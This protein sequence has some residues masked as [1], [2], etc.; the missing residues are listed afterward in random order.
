MI[1]SK[2]RVIIDDIKDNIAV[3]RTEFDAPEVDGVVFVKGANIKQG[4][5]LNVVTEFLSGNLIGSCQKKSAVKQSK[6]PP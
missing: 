6:T 2:I 3:G 1:G 5:F 4:D